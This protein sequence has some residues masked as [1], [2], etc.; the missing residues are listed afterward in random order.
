MKKAIILMLVLSMLAGLVACGGTEAPAAAPQEAAPQEAAPQEAVPQKAVPQEAPEKSAPSKTLNIAIGENILTV[1]PHIANNVSSF[2]SRNMC[3]DPLIESDHMGNFSPCLATDWEVSE[4]GCEIT[5]KLREGVK[6]HNGQDFTSADVVCTFQRLL[7]D[8]TLALRTVYWTLLESVEAVDDY[9]VKIRTTEPYVSVFISLSNTAIIPH[10]LFEE[11]GGEMF[12]EQQL[13]GTGPWIFDEWIDGQYIHVTKNP[14]YWNKAEYDSYYEDV[15]VRVV[16]EPATAVAGQLSGDLQAYVPSGGISADVMPLYEGYEEQIQIEELNTLTTQYIGLSCKDDSPFADKNVR[17]AF[18]HALDRESIAQ[19][20]FGGG[21]VADCF[22]VQGTLGW[23][24]D[25]V[26]YDYDPEL[27]QKYLADSSYDGR[28]ITLS[29]NAATLKS[30]E[31]LLAMSEML[32]AV[33]FKTKVEIVESAV[34]NEMRATGEYDAFMVSTMPEC[35]DPW[36]YLN[37]RILND[38]HHSFYVNEELNSLIEQQNAEMDNAA[39]KEILEKALAMWSQEVVHVPTVRTASTYTHDYGVTGL[40]LYL[41][42][43]YN[44]KFVDYEG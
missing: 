13:V 17:L 36:K 42:G 23:S 35:G 5:F 8:E 28:E 10:E 21:E 27:A 22:M 34:L 39:R 25:I 31:S 6:F 40:G 32:N 24:E 37:I 18:I 4:D 41:D 12:N 38:T 2:Q 43:L 26:H 7:D 11:K 29:S 19:Y 44:F 16:L 3:F 9:T 1:D 14:D 33:G 15:Y 30:Q 20:I